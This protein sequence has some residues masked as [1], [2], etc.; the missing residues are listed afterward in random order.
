MQMVTPNTRAFR[1]GASHAE[2]FSKWW[3]PTQMDAELNGLQ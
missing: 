1:L 2:V 3:R